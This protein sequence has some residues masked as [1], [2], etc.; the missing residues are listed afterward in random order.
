[1]ETCSSVECTSVA[2]AMRRQS[3]RIMSTLATSDTQSSLRL[4]A[5]VTPSNWT[6][7][8]YV[9]VAL[10]NTLGVAETAENLLILFSTLFRCTFIRSDNATDGMRRPCHVQEK[11]ELCR[12]SF[13]TCAH[14]ASRYCFWRRLSVC[15]SVRPHKISK[16]YWS[17]I[18]VTW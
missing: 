3:V 9:D 1:M 7:I 12:I 8:I 18:D 5:Y 6:E 4:S 17:E 15:L 16:N 10:D 14:A 11:R 2:A 13:I